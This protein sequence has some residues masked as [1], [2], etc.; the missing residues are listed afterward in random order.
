MAVFFDNSVG[1]T[2]QREDNFENHYYPFGLTMAGIE[3]QSVRKSLKT[4]ILYND[5]ELQN[6]EFSDGTGLEMYDF[7][8]RFYD[9]QIGR[10]HSIDPLASLSRRWSP[11]NYCYNNPLGMIR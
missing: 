6:K 5:K 4:N 1:G 11:Y 7:G 2:H 9:A 3:F 8:A 10:W